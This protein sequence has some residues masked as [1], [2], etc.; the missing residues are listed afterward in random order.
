MLSIFGKPAKPLENPPESR[1]YI[2]SFNVY[3]RK[4]SI[5]VAPS[6]LS[7]DFS[8][9][10][11]AVAEINNS[12]ADWVHLDVMDGQFVPNLTFGPKLVE[13]L[14]P[15]SSLPFD[16]HLMIR[17]PEKMVEAFARAG[18]GYI[19]FHAE[20]AV[21]SH[22]LLA[23]IRDLGKKAGI[24]IVPSTPV[25]YI[26]ELLS[27]TDL[28]LVMTVNPGFGGQILIPSCLEKVKKL[29]KIREERRL[30]FLLSVDGG[31]NEQTAGLV[32]TA[33]ADVVVTGS[34]FFKDTDKRSLVRRLR[35]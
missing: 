27:C 8:H 22:R 5:I 35:G 32:R 10:A 29:A 6:L 21:H 3:D 13:D 25:Y 15:H 20:A 16:V 14:R 1:L 33:G 19:T 30:S 31:I 34:A 9:F 7:A 24:S 2:V 11:G 4:V 17:E 12:G 28:V 26:E 23:F 18:A